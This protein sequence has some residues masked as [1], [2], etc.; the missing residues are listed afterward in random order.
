MARNFNG[1]TDRINITN[2]TTATPTLLPPYTFAAWFKP[3]NFASAF[4]GI[5]VIMSTTGIYVTSGAQ[6]N[7]FINGGSST[8]ATTL[9][10]GT[11]YH[12]ALTANAVGGVGQGF[13]N[14]VAEGPSMT[15]NGTNMFN[16]GI[17]TIGN[18]G[19]NE[20]FAG[21]IADAAMWTASLTPTEIRQLAYGNV[22]ACQIRPQSLL[23]CWNIDGYGHP[24]LDYALYKRNGILTGTTF[25]P[26]PPLISAAPIFP[27]VPMGA[28]MTIQPPTFV[29]MPQ[30]VM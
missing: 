14:G 7:F 4:G 20:A 25:V 8:G 22:R 29:L 5:I 16:G 26:G 2:A 15:P 27:G 9:S 1:S 10:A 23:I 11:W 3:A 21:V 12:T 19:A 28:L 18:D 6:L 17:I 30:I 24:A 13:L